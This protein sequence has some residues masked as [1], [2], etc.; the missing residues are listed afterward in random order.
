MTANTTF[1]LYMETL[2][3]VTFIPIFRMNVCLYHILSVSHLPTLFPWHDNNDGTANMKSDLFTWTLLVIQSILWQ[4]LW[5]APFYNLKWHIA[6]LERKQTDKRKGGRKCWWTSGHQ[7]WPFASTIK[8]FCIY[9]TR[10]W[11]YFDNLKRF[12][13]HMTRD[14]L[15]TCAIARWCSVEWNLHGDFCNSNSKNSF[16]FYFTRTSSMINCLY[17]RNR[18]RTF[19]KTSNTIDN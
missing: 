2:L 7:V 13:A 6:T 3:I 14:Q 9:H 4:F 18:K 19:L 1:E 15:Q 11:K 12:T 16:L 8:N 5:F 10:R 17:G